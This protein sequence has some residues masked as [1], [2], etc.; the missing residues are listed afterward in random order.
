MSQSLKK[1]MYEHFTLKKNNKNLKSFRCC[2]ICGEPFKPRSRFERYCY[3]CK[4]KDELF[5]FGNWLPE[6]SDQLATMFL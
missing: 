3:D 1:E 4:G 6:L 2:N 5:K